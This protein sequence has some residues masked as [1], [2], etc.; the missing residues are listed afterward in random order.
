MLP[1]GSHILLPL[2]HYYYYYY[3]YY[4]RQ[5]LEDFERLSAEYVILF[6]K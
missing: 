2:H 6:R 4:S 3:S 5:L 1:K